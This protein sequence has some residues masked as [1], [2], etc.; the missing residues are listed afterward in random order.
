M[1]DP[2]DVERRLRKHFAE[3]TPEEFLR[4]VK[5]TTTDSEW[6]ELMRNRPRPGVVT[7]VR[8][9]LRRLLPPL[10]PKPAGPARSR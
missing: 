4:I 9:A 1:L 3:V 8:L 10:R 5:R 6:R 7:R 2:D